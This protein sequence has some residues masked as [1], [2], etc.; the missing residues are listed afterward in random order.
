[1]ELHPEEKKYYTRLNCLDGNP[2]TLFEFLKERGI[3]LINRNDLEKL[4][5]Y[6]E[7][8]KENDFTINK[9]EIIKNQNQNRIIGTLY[10]A[11]LNIPVICKFTNENTNKLIVFPI[12]SKINVY[13]DSNYKDTYLITIDVD[14][15]APLS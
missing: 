7:L 6:P 11:S 8:L 4:K 2:N 5:F 15:Y 1:M 3:P 9:E 13:D 12:G 10:T 14:D